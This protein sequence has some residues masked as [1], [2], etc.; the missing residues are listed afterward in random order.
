MG[1]FW[2]QII[3][4]F[5]ENSKAFFSP[6]FYIKDCMTISIELFSSMGQG[7]TK[8][9]RGSLV[10]PWYRIIGPVCKGLLFYMLI[11]AH[12]H[13]APF[14]SQ[15]KNETKKLESFITIG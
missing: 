10:V 12:I 13:K 9:E 4:E 6:K 14:S 8:A 1:K 11:R 15:F 7:Y 2:L 5:S 3:S